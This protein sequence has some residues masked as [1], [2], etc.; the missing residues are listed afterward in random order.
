[1]GIFKKTALCTFVSV[2]LIACGGGDDAPQT[3]STPS[4][5]T[6]TGVLTDGAVG[7]V[8]YTTTSGV[9]GETDVQGRFKFNKGDKVTFK[10]GGVTLGGAVNAQ[11]T[12]TPIDLAGVGANAGVV[13]NNLLVF[14]QSLDSDGNHDNGITILPATVTAAASVTLD[15][16]QATAAF[17]ANSAFTGL[18]ASVSSTGAKLVTPTD[19][20]ANFKKAFFESIQG[21]WEMGHT[22]EKAI[23]FRFS[24]HGDY[25]MGETGAADASGSSGIEFGKIDWNPLTGVITATQTIDTNG[26][27]G[28]SH[29]ANDKPYKLRLNGNNL[30]IEES[31]TSVQGTFTRVTNNN[32]SIVGTWALGSATIFKTQNFTFFDNGYYLLSDTEGDSGCGSPG[33]EFGKYHLSGSNLSVTKSEVLFDTNGCAGLADSDAGSSFIFNLNT[34]DKTAILSSPSEGGEVTLFRVSL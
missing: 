29:P 19:A 21:V 25:I 15:F 34:N 32:A 5:G 17:S 33:V 16:T 31:G 7:G 2:S 30:V 23:V 11:A 14:L 27:W 3:T 6:E 10:I 9:T 8:S 18:I 26:H 1:M 4:T 24:V 22:T 20:Q 12:L 28:L 13:A